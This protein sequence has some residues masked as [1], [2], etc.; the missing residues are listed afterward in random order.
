MKKTF[1]LLL[2]CVLLLTISACSKKGTS[3]DVSATIE[4]IKAEAAKMDVAQLRATAVS[5]KDAIVA[6][7]TELSKISDQVKALNPTEMLGQKATQLKSQMADVQK[8]I[9]DLK[10]RFMVYYEQVK[11]KAGD[12]TGLELP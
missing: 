6:K 7:Q 4:Q 1:L 12:L 5:Y 9:S 8:S 2:A 11:A 3:V 10:D